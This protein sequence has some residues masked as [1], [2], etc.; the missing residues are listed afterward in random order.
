MVNQDRRTTIRINI[1]ELGVSCSTVSV[2]SIK[3]R[4]W[5]TFMQK[6]FQANV[7]HGVQVPR[8]LPAE[9]FFKTISEDIQEMPQSRSTTLSRHQKK[10]R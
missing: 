2:Y 1:E 10:E 6:C 9:G 7:I 4:F 3:F 8:A 5:E